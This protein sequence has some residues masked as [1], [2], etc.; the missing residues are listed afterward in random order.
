M[1]R[2]QITN[3]RNS[4]APFFAGSIAL[5]S[6]RLSFAARATSHGLQSLKRDEH[7]E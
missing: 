1:M 5:A 2:N 7:G 3:F 4:A 6:G